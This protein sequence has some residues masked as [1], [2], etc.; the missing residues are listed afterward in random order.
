[1]F[2]KFIF[3]FLVIGS[4]SAAPDLLD[5]TNP[6]EFSDKIPQRLSETCRPPQ[7]SD[8]QHWIPRGLKR[9][10]NRELCFS[11][12]I[13]PA[14]AMRKFINPPKTQ[15]VKQWIL[16]MSSQE[17]V[18]MHL[19]VLSV[20]GDILYNDWTKNG[21]G[22][23]RQ[24]L[25]SLE[26]TKTDGKHTLSEKSR[27]AVVDDILKRTALENFPEIIFGILNHTARY[28]A[29]TSKYRVPTGITER[30]E[31]V[32]S[33]GQRKIPLFRQNVEDP[34]RVLKKFL[35]LPM[36][37]GYWE[38]DCA[39]S[40]YIFVNFSALKQLDDVDLHKG[41]YNWL[42]KN[43]IY[44]RD[45]TLVGL[46]LLKSLAKPNR[47]AIQ[48]M[49]K[50]HLGYIINLED[51]LTL[52]STIPHSIHQGI[53][54]VTCGP[55]TEGEPTY[56]GFGPAFASGPLSKIKVYEYLIG[57]TLNDPIPE[58]DKQYLI[59]VTLQNVL[60]HAWQEKKRTS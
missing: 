48:I 30:I 39:W 7:D 2:F 58:N 60:K 35:T 43:G 12:E 57:H 40:G 47:P 23:L 15:S 49:E 13:T 20:I 16:D 45:L 10:V 8:K 37:G 1:M 36:S 31:P 53:N 29:D 54:V 4:L 11:L 28:P 50:G 33:H 51:Y 22:T 55:N 44:Q 25:K 9:D 18:E 19:F 27:L 34:S 52:F 5:Q 6:E 17:T 42:I 14:E 46:N 21:Q 26:V 56:I 3:A 38:I 24:R 32:D 41:T 59:K